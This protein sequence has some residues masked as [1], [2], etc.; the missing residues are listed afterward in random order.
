MTDKDPTLAS[1]ELSTSINDGD[2]TPASDERPARSRKGWPLV[3][4]VGV[5]VVALA[6]Y[7]GVAL[8]GTDQ[9]PHGTTV[10]GVILG[11]QSKAAA[12]KRLQGHVTAVRSRPITFTAAGRTLK[13][14]PANAGLGLDTTGAFDGLTGFTLN[15]KTL[16]ERYSGGPSRTLKTTVD[17]AKLKAA[18]SA[19]GASLKGAPVL[20]TVKFIGGQVKVTHS[21]PGRG[22]DATALAAKIAA[23]W[24]A[25]R[26]YSA[27][28][29]QQAPVLTN[30]TIDAFA[31]G[32]AK[33]AMSG[34]V[35]FVNGTKKVDVTV[36]QLSA[37]LKTEPSGNS[38]KIAVIPS[39]MKALAA[40]ISLQ[41]TTPAKLAKVKMNGIVPTKQAIAG[42][43]GTTIDPTGTAAALI[44]ALQSGKRT[45][46]VKL[47]TEKGT[48][49]NPA[50]VPTTKIS[51]FRSPFPTGPSNAARTVNIRNGLS[52]LNGT[53]VAPGQQISLLSILEPFTRANGFVPAPVLVGG[54]DVNGLGGG[55]SQ[56][57][58]T[59]YNA[60]F[61]AGVQEDVHQAHTVYISRYPMGRE[62]TLAV[63]TV[64]NKW[65][66][67]TGHGIVIQA[68]IENN[69]AVMRLY[70]TKVF[71]VTS[72]T[73]S[74]FDV[75][76]PGSQRVAGPGCIP[77][78]PVN[79]F[80]VTVTRVV[81]QGGK[82]VKNESLTTTYRP[83]DRVICTG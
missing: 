67:D 66:N 21:T 72:T 29:A 2:Q 80:K 34:P 75:R 12:Q 74:P 26:S 6:A 78:A 37:I 56:V 73:G 9:V 22:I 41:I 28:M 83:A 70:G 15:P 60:T 69:A 8:T 58:T 39:Q 68:D 7:G 63:P 40:S 62:A 36:R 59:M 4:G 17:Q 11:G 61:F 19:S 14:T 79:G 30:A 18:I 46:S 48:T 82:V 45:V 38:L 76:P 54:R 65:T 16:W 55:S 49:V 42:A 13:I 81:K 24:P 31:A 44:S 1:G 35:T 25:T 43:N 52:K 5:V 47:A 33:A 20:G 3:A 77:Q 27:S 32:P 51:E 23:G 53:Y 57:S 10:D 64:D 50:E 71:T